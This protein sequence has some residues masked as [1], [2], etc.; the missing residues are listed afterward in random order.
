MFCVRDLSEYYELQETV[1]N[2]NSQV[3]NL[4]SLNLIMYCLFIS[5][6]ISF[7][8]TYNSLY[9]KIYSLELGNGYIRSILIDNNLNLN[10]EENSEEEE[11]IIDDSN[12]DVNSSDSGESS[13]E[14]I[15]ET[16]KILKKEVLS[17][18]LNKENKN[19]NSDSSNE[20]ETGVVSIE[21]EPDTTEPGILNNVRT[22]LGN[23]V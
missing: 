22:L 19:R 12:S 15:N 20:F 4:S 10:K 17:E 11:D 8:T 16:N 6:F 1:Y 18:L 21:K 23:F 13:D 5:I 2:L 7:I 9:G 3:N 14:S